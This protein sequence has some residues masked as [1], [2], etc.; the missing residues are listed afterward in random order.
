M[1]RQGAKTVKKSG[2]SAGSEPSHLAHKVEFE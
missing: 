2:T 1:N